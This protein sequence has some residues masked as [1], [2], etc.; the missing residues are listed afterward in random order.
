[1]HGVC[2]RALGMPPCAGFGANKLRKASLDGT[3]KSLE[4]VSELRVV[5]GEP[6]LPMRPVC[7]QTAFGAPADV[8]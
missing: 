8:R 7:L 1:M 3:E 2:I 4:H 5:A 6:A